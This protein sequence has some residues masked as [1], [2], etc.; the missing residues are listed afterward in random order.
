MAENQQ[1]DDYVAPTPNTR[2]RR[3]GTVVLG[4]L[5]TV[6]LL[7]I[8]ALAFTA[9]SGSRTAAAGTGLDGDSSTAEPAP[10]DLAAASRR[11]DEQVASGWVPFEDDRPYSGE[12]VSGWVPIAPDGQSLLPAFDAGESRLP[13]YVERGGGAVLGYVYDYIGFVPVALAE[14]GSF[15][16]HAVRSERVGCDPLGTDGVRDAA[17]VARWMESQRG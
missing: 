3:T 7:T 15:D 9:L 10:E 6:V 2:Q 16:P 11:L 1:L 13:V 4:V 12:P 14:S 8:G 5:A 17:C